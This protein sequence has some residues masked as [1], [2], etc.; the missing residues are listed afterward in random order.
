MF[1]FVYDYLIT[2]EAT[3][4]PRI[5]IKLHAHHEVSVHRLPQTGTFWGV[6]KLEGHVNRRP[7][8]LVL[9]S[10]L[11]IYYSQ[12]NKRESTKVINLSLCFAFQQVVHMLP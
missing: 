5:Q 3:D 4:R 9:S 2:M 12:E 8:S 7:F 6:Y 10:A 11:D 1:L